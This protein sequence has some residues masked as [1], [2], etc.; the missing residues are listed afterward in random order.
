MYE[1]FFADASDQTHRGCSHLD[2]GFSSF[3]PCRPDV[4]ALASKVWLV[5]TGEA[6]E[7]IQYAQRPMIKDSLAV[8]AKLCDDADAE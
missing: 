2:D 7:G 4:H 6:E 3:I 5:R 1:H 8:L